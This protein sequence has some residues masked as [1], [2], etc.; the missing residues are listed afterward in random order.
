MFLCPRLLYR[1]G[2]DSVAKENTRT[3]T[4]THTHA[5]AHTHTHTHIRT[6][7]HAHTHTHTHIRTQAH[8]H[9]HTHTHIYTRIRKTVDVPSILTKIF[10]WVFPERWVHAAHV[11]SGISPS[12]GFVPHRKRWVVLPE[13]CNGTDFV[14][15]WGTLEYYFSCT[16]YTASWIE[17]ISD[18][19]VVVPYLYIKYIYIYICIYTHTYIKSCYISSETTRSCGGIW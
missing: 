13:S 19:T 18:F 7:A 16:L 12:D 8:A 5:H 10:L 17:E 15:L 11:I 1:Q 4:R 6:H 14:F 2:T 3:H 9:A